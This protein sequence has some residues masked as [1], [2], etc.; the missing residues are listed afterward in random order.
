VKEAAFPLSIR[1]PFVR[2]L[3]LTAVILKSRMQN[4]R[5]TVTSELRDTVGRTFR[6]RAECSG[7]FGGV[8]DRGKRLAILVCFGFEIVSATSVLGKHYVDRDCRHEQRRWAPDASASAV[9]GHTDRYSSGSPSRDPSANGPL[10]QDRSK[11]FGINERLVAVTSLFFGVFR[12]SLRIAI[13]RDMP[14]DI[15]PNSWLGFWERLLVAQS[16]E[17][18]NT[19]RPVRRHPSRKERHSSQ[20]NDRGSK[21]Y[22]VR[23]REAV[24]PT[25]DK[26]G[27]SQR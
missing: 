23:W 10:G 18:I 8:W 25:A 20:E 26:P 5:T 21:S 12:A 4:V 1:V 27:G 15:A 11:T 9:S 6:F 17:W 24:K 22:G 2:S 14:S 16:Y 7:G 13:A 19:R 3:R